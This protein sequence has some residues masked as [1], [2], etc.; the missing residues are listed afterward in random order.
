[1]GTGGGC[2]SRTRSRIDF[3]RNRVS[4]FRGAEYV[5]DLGGLGTGTGER[6][7]KTQSMIGD[8]SSGSG[9]YEEIA[10][11]AFDILLEFADRPLFFRPRKDAR[12]WSVCWLTFNDPRPWSPVPCLEPLPFICARSRNLSGIQVR[13]A[14]VEVVD[15]IPWSGR[16]AAIPVVETSCRC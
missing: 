13:R 5:V 3:G 8:R 11:G 7:S 10:D 15:K 9:V 6:T 4:R 16:S 14:I 12:P 1:M 2:S